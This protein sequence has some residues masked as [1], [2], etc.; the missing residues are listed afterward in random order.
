M[1]EKDGLEAYKKWWHAQMKSAS[2]DLIPGIDA[3]ARAANATWF[4]WDDGSL[5][6]HWRWPEFHQSIICDGLKVYFLSK[7]PAFKR[8]Q[9][10]N[11]SPD[12]MAK[13]AK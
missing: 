1:W 8:A 4:E 12:M 7:K 10:A 5:P 11:K 9:A 3:V 13:N 2:W 6:F